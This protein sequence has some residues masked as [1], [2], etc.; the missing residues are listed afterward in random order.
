MDDSLE[1]RKFIN[2]Q[3]MALN[4]PLQLEIVTCMQSALAKNVFSYTPQKFT[5][6]ITLSFVPTYLTE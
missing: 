5:P 4:D 2:K 1:I 3:S 6:I